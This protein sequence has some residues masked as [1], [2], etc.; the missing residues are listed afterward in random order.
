M[1]GPNLVKLRLLLLL[2]LLLVV[3]LLDQAEGFLSLLDI[4]LDL[5]H[6]ILE[7]L[8]SLLLVTLGSSINAAALCA[9]FLDLLSVCLQV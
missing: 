1:G 3:S 6:L 8:H 9:S 5:P 4:L 7:G 2:E